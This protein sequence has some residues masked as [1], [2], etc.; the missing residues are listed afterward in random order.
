MLLIIPMVF[1]G[2]V[3]LIRSLTGILGLWLLLSLGFSLAIAIFVAGSV[4]LFILS[5]IILSSQK[6]E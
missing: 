4:L 3:Q 1:N 6:G 2:V 5:L